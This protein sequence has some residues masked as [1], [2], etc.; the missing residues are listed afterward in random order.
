MILRFCL[1]GIDFHRTLHLTLGLVGMYS[2]VTS[3]WAVKK[4]LH[5]CYS[6]YVF[7]MSLKDH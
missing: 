1:I 7:Q 6:E 3:I 4:K 5:I 2:T